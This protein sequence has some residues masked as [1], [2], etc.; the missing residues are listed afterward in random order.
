[1]SAPLD[2][3]EPIESFEP[4]QPDPALEAAVERIIRSEQERLEMMSEF[5]RN[6]AI[7]IERRRLQSEHEQPER[8]PGIFT[9]PMEQI[10]DI[11]E[12]LINFAEEFPESAAS[13][14]FRSDREV[15]IIDVTENPGFSEEFLDRY[16]E[17][18]QQGLERIQHER[19][20]NN[21]RQ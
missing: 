3:P 14:N 13:F 16:D 10:D 9:G 18:I 17:A 2:P 19:E 4:E 1:M 11:E 8:E 5:E 21:G 12:H 7:A 20:E 6:R 15:R